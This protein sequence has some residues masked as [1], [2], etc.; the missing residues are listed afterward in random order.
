[1]TLIIND[2]QA[3][4]NILSIKASGARM[5]TMLHVTGLYCIN[6]VNEHG[7]TTPMNKLIG[8]IGKNTRKEAFIT[9][10][11]DHSKVVSL[12]TGVL[13]YRKDRKLY[14]ANGI[15]CNNEVALEKAESVPFWDYTK[16]VKPVSSYDVLTR[17]ESLLKSAKG[18][19]GDVK[20]AELLATLQVIVDASKAGDTIEL[21]EPETAAS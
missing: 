13:E 5:D 3:K 18:F 10:L 6:Q 2:T 7:N 21:K 20:H 14:D 1:M 16:E 8:A 19:V 4:R 12:K 15:E 11:R 17:L 9:W